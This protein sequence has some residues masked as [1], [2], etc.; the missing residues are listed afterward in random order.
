GRGSLVLLGLVVIHDR[1]KPG[2]SINLQGAQVHRV[3][4]AYN[5][6]CA[7]LKDSHLKCW[8]D[9]KHGQL[10]YDDTQNRYQPDLKAIDFGGKRVINFALGINSVCAVL[11]DQ[12]LR[13]WGST[14]YT[15]LGYPNKDLFREP[16]F[17]APIL[18]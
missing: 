7:L 5:T 10:G 12:T 2:P 11:E 9:N 13:C 14:A 16:L 8:G 17:E 3:G 15:S 4:A 18:P 1:G 6:T